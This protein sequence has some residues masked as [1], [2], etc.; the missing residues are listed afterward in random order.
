MENNLYKQYKK[1]IVPKLKA[2]LKLSNIMQVPKINKVV[3]NVGVGRF[4][5]ESGYIENVESTLTKITGQKPIR[6][7]AKKAISNFK[8][9]QGMEIGVMVTLRGKRMYD[10]L[11]KFLCLTL[12]RVRDF[13]GISPNSFDKV[14]NYTL[15]MKEHL[16]FPEI[17]ADE[18]DK[19][20]G[21]EVAICT[22]ASNAD[23]GRKL[24]A[25]LGFPFKK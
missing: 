25:M 14:G 20:H 11:E 2:E 4:L 9:R 19:I 16:S 5:K 8:V 6:T 13:R 12:P 10:F 21:L 15:G 17:R 3:L 1:V 23:E 7:K 24:L 22:T 18:V